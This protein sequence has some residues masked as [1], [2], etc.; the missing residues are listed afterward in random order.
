MFG[1][2][3]A[4]IYILVD[5]DGTYDAAAAPFLVGRVLKDDLDFVNGARAEVSQQAYRPGHRLGNR[6][7]P[8]SSRACSGASSGTCSRATRSCRAAS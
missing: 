7:S 4:D 2:V 6:S 8:A 3:E 1:D 5:G